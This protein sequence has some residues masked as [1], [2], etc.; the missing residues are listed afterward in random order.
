[1]VRNHPDQRFCCRACGDEWFMAERR[2][3]VAWFRGLG[4]RP[5]LNGDQRK[6]REA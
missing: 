2:Q 4:M 3:A 1:M 5:E 6:E